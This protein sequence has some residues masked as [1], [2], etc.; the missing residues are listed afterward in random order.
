M[1]ECGSFPERAN[2]L[3][4]ISTTNIHFMTCCFL[5]L[6]PQL[7]NAW[8]TKP[9]WSKPTW[10]APAWDG[11]NWSKPTKRPVS[12]WSGWNNWGPP[13]TKKPTNHP[14]DSW[15]GSS[16]GGE[17]TSTN[18][19]LNGWNEDAWGNNDA[20]AGSGWWGWGSTPTPPSSDCCLT[21]Y[22]AVCPGDFP[23][24]VPSHQPGEQGCCKTSKGVLGPSTPAC[25]STPPPTTSSPTKA[26][27]PQPTVTP[28][29]PSPTPKDA[30][31]KPSSQPSSE[32]SSE[33]TSPPSL[34][35]SPTPKDATSEPSSSPSISSQPTHEPSA[36]TSSPS[37]S[38]SPSSEPSSQPSSEPS[39]QPSVQPSAT[40]SSQPSSQ[41]SSEPSVQPSLQP[42]QCIPNGVGNLPVGE[43]CSVVGDPNTFN[44]CRCC[45]GVCNVNSG[46]NQCVATPGQNSEQC[47]PPSLS[48][49][50][51]AAPTDV[52]ATTGEV[53][54]FFPDGNSNY[55]TSSEPTPPVPVRPDDREYC[56][57][58]CNTLQECQEMCSQVSL[59]WGWTDDVQ[60]D[61]RMP[62]AGCFITGS[63]C[64]YGNFEGGDFEGGG[65]YEADEIFEV[66]R[67]KRLCCD[68]LVL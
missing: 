59:K 56:L 48:P 2:N 27:T 20:W 54:T 35:Q 25:Q 14:V 28:T 13:P 44:P 46:N 19:V 11:W 26:P 49:S 63:R 21:T 52:A 38:S 4:Y 55:E 68:D 60:N 43:V 66:D 31:P 10:S 40:P 39:F 30:T 18:W 32:P 42:T 3:F 50:I 58:A 61:L 36:I 51:S 8:N 65:G 33:P 9:R 1:E 62:Y 16:W 23:I 15:W 6:K 5:L 47:V 37:I 7:S 67:R 41:P 22:G 24:K 57:E 12:P 29:T 17:G 45:S 53:P 34:S 64:F